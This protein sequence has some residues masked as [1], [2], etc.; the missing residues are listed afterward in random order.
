[1]QK[2]TVM[3]IGQPLFSPSANAPQF[4]K[5]EKIFNHPRLGD[6]TNVTTSEIVSVENGVIETRNTIYTPITQ[7]N[8]QHG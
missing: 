1:M 5:L 8:A 2:V 7:E 3:Y 4:A 6:C